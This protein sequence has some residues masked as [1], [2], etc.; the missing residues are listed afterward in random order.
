MH[1]SLEHKVSELESAV[2]ALEAR[3]ARLEAGEAGIAVE[4]HPVSYT[5]LRAHET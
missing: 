1:E 3:M 2:H 4:A 5:H